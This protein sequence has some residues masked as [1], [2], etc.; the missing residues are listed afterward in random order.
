VPELRLTPGEQRRDF[1]Y[2]DDV[3]DA[4]MLVL[5]RRTELTGQV[6][7]YD[8]GSG[9]AVPV[10]EFVEL[11]HR[12]THSRTRLEFGAVSYRPSE[13]MFAQADI[14]ALESLGWLCSTPAEAGVLKTM[15]AERVS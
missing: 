5:A 8:V 1:V 10:R 4:Y 2:V 13:V 3:V 9:V 7:E 11:V 14:G 15:Q 12:V 6:V